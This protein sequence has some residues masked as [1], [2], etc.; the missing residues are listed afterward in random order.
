MVSSDYRHE[1]FQAGV[2][3]SGINE[4]DELVGGGLDRGTNNLLMGPAGTS[5][6]GEATR[7]REE[8][9]SVASHELR[10]PLTSLKLMTQMNQRMINGQSPGI[11]VAQLESVFNLFERATSSKNIS[12]LGLGL[13]ICR[14]IVT[15]H[16]GQIRVADDSAI[17]TKFVA[18][19]PFEQDNPPI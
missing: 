17:G 1:A 9:I 15:S 10:T 19:L 2:A 11:P 14:Q 12:G 3:S 7:V 18:E 16:G 4:L 8:F 5:A 13:Y 6:Q